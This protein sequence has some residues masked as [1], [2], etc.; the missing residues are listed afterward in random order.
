MEAGFKNGSRHSDVFV[1]SC[2]NEVEI[3]DDYEWNF[4]DEEGNGSIDICCN[5]CNKE[6]EIYTYPEPQYDF[7]L[8]DEE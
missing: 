4:Q 7:R 1:C 3:P 5:V 8:I 6:W 2:G